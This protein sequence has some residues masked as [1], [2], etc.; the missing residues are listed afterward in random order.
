[1]GSHWFRRLRLAAIDPP[2]ETS[3]ACVWTETSSCLDKEPQLLSGQGTAMSPFAVVPVDRGVGWRLTDSQ[4]VLLLFTHT[5]TV[6]AIGTGIPFTV[7]V[8]V[9]CMHTGGSS[10][11]LPSR[12]LLGLARRLRSNR[13]LAHRRSRSLSQL[14]CPN[15]PHGCPM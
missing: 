7:T 1:M 9:R 2:T 13:D 10:L 15:C 6:P 11:S 14:H 5:G 4:Y 3:A 12:W 8:R